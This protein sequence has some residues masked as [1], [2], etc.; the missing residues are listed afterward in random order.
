M[1]I[2]V[3]PPE[4]SAK[5]AA[6]KGFTFTL[7]SDPEGKVIDAW[8]IRN[9]DNGELALH[10]AFLVDA[11]KTI[12]YRKVARRRVGPAEL[13]HAIDGDAVICCPGGCGDKPDCRPAP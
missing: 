10:G 12:T 9:Q 2:S 5:W 11:D 6:E 3:D 4:T 7:L 8:G 1:L 13:L